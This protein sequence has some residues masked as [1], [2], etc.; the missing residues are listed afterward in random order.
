MLPRRR[1]L[2]ILLTNGD[3]GDTTVLGEQQLRLRATND[4]V[5]V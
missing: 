3:S 2:F 4:R 1:S 5:V